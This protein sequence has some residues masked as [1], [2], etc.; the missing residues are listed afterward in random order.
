MSVS[1]SSP[2]RERAINNQ[3]N[4]R[5]GALQILYSLSQ[6]GLL[7]HPFGM[8]ASGLEPPDTSTRIVLFEKVGNLHYNPKHIEQ[9]TQ[10][11]QDLSESLLMFDDEIKEEGQIIA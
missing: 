3:L 11:I 2:L 8:W 7:A 5:H 4:C 1:G 6:Y 10:A 9:Y